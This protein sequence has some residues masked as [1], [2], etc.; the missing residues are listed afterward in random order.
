MK[1][2]AI[3]ITMLTT[4][5]A[6]YAQL[7]PLANFEATTINS[8]QASNVWNDM[9]TNFVSGSECFNR[10]MS[11]TFD[12]NQKYGFDAK[13]ILIHY[14]YLYNKELSSKWG[15]HIAPMYNVEGNDTVFDKGF[16]AWLH[17]PLPPQ[18]WEE[19]FLVAGTE[20]LVEKRLEIM[21]KIEKLEKSIKDLDPSSSFYYEDLKSRRDKVAELRAELKVFKIT[22]Q[23]LQQQRPKKIEQATRWISFLENELK[24]HRSNNQIVNQI[25]M[26]LNSYKTLLG[27]V[28]TDLNYAAHIS[29]E[30]ITHIEELDYNKTGAWCFIQEV[31]QYYWGVPQLRNL[32]YGPGF[33]LTKLPSLA[34]LPARR[35]EGANYEKTDFDMTEVWTARRQAFGM[36][37]KEIWKVEY[38]LRENASD[39]VKD[40]K[41]LS[42]DV[43]SEVV[44][45]HKLA[46]NIEKLIA[47]YPTLQKN[48]VQVRTLTAQASQYEQTAIMADERIQQLAKNIDHTSNRTKVEEFN[49]AKN[50]LAQVEKNKKALEG[51][52]SNLKKQIKEIDAAQRQRNRD[53]RRNRRR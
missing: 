3:A 41:K 36:K 47:D 6:A 52:E 42:K 37:F 48:L 27:K 45:V 22:D 30:K 38:D 17:T 21:K 7:S 44:S 19:K 8:Q 50:A 51:I 15:Y 5:F 49:K 53:D 28:K 13:K 20:K 9:K 33:G 29:C 18:M 14:S 34:D 23:D 24:K 25:N 43:S 35:Q 12:I 2:S 11:W 10:A 26:Q 4:S 31:S 16:G 40:I 46:N 39:A 32:N 1:I